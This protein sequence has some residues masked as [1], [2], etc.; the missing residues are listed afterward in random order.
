MSRLAFGEAFR[1]HAVR[2]DRILSSPWCR[3]LDAARLMAMGPVDSTW[4][5]AASDKSPDRLAALKQL[6]SIEGNTNP[7]RRRSSRRWP[8]GP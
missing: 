1:R 4:T 3:C 8:P 7:V 6:V 5:A 2:V